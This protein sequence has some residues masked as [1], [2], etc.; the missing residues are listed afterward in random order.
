M[1]V[2]AKPRFDVVGPEAHDRVAVERY[3]RQKYSNS[4]DSDLSHF[5]PFLI[6][7]K[8]DHELSAAVG[9]RR[10][11]KE[12]LF[13]EHYLNQPVEKELASLFSRQAIER[14]SIVEFGNLVATWRGSSQLVF[15]FLT[16]LL[17]ATNIEWVVFTATAELRKILNRLSFTPFVLCQAAVENLGEESASWG[18]Y[19]DTAPMVMV[20]HLPS[21]VE[22][23]K[24]HPLYNKMKDYVSC[25]VDEAVQE[26][27]RVFP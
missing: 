17:C 11:D 18:T 13:L 9:L 23:M 14:E 27:G 26:W 3:I 20:G 25:G 6:T 12:P 8:C 19:Y 5:L 24:Q 21:A 7:L 2:S 22:I 10:A 1:P 15:I 4:Y 16:H